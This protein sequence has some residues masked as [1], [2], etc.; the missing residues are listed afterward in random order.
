MAQARGKMALNFKYFAFGSNL[1]QQRM[2]IKNPKSKFL[3]KAKLTDYTLKFGN[4]VENWLGG[5]ATI[6]QSPNDFVWGG[7]LRS[8]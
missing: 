2:H 3:C 1:L 4:Y 8:K 7:S 5:T 6:V